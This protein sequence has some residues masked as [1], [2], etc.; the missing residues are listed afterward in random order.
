VE[1]LV[2]AL[3]PQWIFHLAAASSPAKSWE[4]PARTLH[5]NIGCQANVLAAAVT[6]KAPP[7]VLV[8]ARRTSTASSPSAATEPSTKRLH[9]GP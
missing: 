6:L 9:Y 7:A 2:Q 3:R 1:E 4:D 5:T 8:V